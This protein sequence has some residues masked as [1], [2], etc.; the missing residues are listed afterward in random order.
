MAT[1]QDI[2]IGY[3]NL[4]SGT[5]QD[6]FLDITIGG[7]GPTNITISASYKVRYIGTQPQELR[8][9]LAPRF[10]IK[11]IKPQAFGMKFIKAPVIN[12]TYIEKKPI[13]VKFI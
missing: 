5:A 9:V 2:L 6:L 12:V 10:D 13:K 4:S 8:Y 3:S 7:G 1:A 11:Y